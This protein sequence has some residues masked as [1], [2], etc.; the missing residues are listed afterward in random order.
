MKIP[1][2][3]RVFQVAIRSFPRSLR[4]AKT[5]LQSWEVQHFQPMNVRNIRSPASIG[6]QFSQTLV[7]EAIVSRA[8]FHRRRFMFYV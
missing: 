8:A 2:S 3:A 5:Y 6:C 1:V 7:D 4:I